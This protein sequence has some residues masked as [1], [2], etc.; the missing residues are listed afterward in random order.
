MTPELRNWYLSNLGITQYVPKG[1]GPVALSFQSP[2]SEEPLP[3]KASHVKKQVASVLELV[4]GKSSRVE[5]TEDQ[6]ATAEESPPASK[7]RDLPAE[8]PQ[9]ELPETPEVVAP[10]PL[11]HFRIAC[12]HP[13]DDLLVFNSFSPGDQPD[14]EQNQLLSNMLRAVGRLPNGLPMPE[15]IDWPVGSAQRADSVGDTGREGAKA[16][17]SVFLNARIQKYGVLWVLLMGELATEL[18]SSNDQPYGDALGGTEDIA[19]G[20]KIVVI[21]SL[22]EML[23]EPLSKAD[24]WQTIRPLVLK[25]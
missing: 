12:W 22:Q 5:S 17:L 16:M 7:G 24:T 10:D 9:K 14:T 25:H 6:R 20:A 18:L 23:V 15:F 21:R 11:L 4:E 1:E 3:P 2:A 13:C 8:L 19:G